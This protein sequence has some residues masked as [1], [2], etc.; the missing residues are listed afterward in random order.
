MTK[1]TILVSADEYA[2]F[3]QFQKTLQKSL[4]E[5][6]SVTTF[7]ESRKT[8]LFSSLNKWVIASSATNHMICNSDMFSSFRSHKTLSSVTVATV[9]LVTLLDQ[10]LLNQLQL[11]PCHLSQV[12]QSWPLIWSLPE[13]SIVISHS[14]WIIVCFVILRQIRYLV[15]DIYLMISIFWWM[16]SSIWCLLQYCVSIQNTLS[17][18]TS[19]FTYVKEVLSPI[20]KCFFRKLWVMSIC[21]TPSHLGR[22]K[23]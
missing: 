23:G 13:T 8:C 17:V 11:L 6:I 9:Q 20:S 12:Y 5:P 3:S 2:K 14:F 4:K 22:S 10:E 18:G 15:R 21:K 7:A 19:F 16:G 1:K